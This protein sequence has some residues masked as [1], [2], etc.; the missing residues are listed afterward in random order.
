[1]LNV[2]SE[3]SEMKGMGEAGSPAKGPHAGSPLR[4]GRPETQKPFKCTG[5]MASHPLH[6]AQSIQCSHLNGSQKDLRSLGSAGCSGRI[7]IARKTISGDLQLL[8]PE[9]TNTFHRFITVGMRLLA[10][11]LEASQIC[12]S[13]T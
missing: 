13:L 4:S 1:M 12:F 11:L 8:T 5:D 7:S 2:S 6:L 10:D 3:R 9:P